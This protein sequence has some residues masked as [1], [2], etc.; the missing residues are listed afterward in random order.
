[1]GVS[2]T[3]GGVTGDGESHLDAV[4]P[5]GRYALGGVSADGRYVAFVS[6]ANNLVP[7]QTE[8]NPSNQVFLRDT[9]A[10][11]TTVVSH[12]FKS[13]VTT[14]NSESN[15]PVLSA[16]GRYVA[17]VSFAHNLV[18]EGSNRT[19]NGYNVF[20]YD[21]LTGLNTLVS[22]APGNF[23]Q[24]A[25]GDTPAISADG[26]WVAFSGKAAN[27]VAGITDTDFDTN[28]LLYNV[29]AGST[30]LITFDASNPHQTAQNSAAD[31]TPVLS[32]DGRYVAYVSTAAD[33]DGT[34]HDTNGAENVFRF[35]RVAGTNTLITRATTGMG[36]A[37]NGSS[38]APSISADGSR[39]AFVSYAT[40]LVPGQLEVAGENVFVS[41]PALGLVLVSHAQGAGR[42]TGDGSSYTPV[43]S[44][45]G[46]AIA[47]VSR[48][49]DLVANQGSFP[50][51]ENVFLFAVG[52]AGTNTLV[53]HAY[54]SATAS[55]GY[56]NAP[57]ISADGKAVA[58]WSTAGNLV[59]GQTGG[60]QNVFGYD[61]WLGAVHLISHVP[62]SDSTP[63]S[64]G[65]TEAPVISAD[66]KFIAFATR[67]SNL[68]SGDVIQMS[69]VFIADHPLFN[70]RFLVPV[71][72]LG[73]GQPTGARARPP[74]FARLI[75]V[76]VGKQER[77]LVE[78]LFAD[79]GALQSEF[80]APFQGPRYQ[81][82]QVRTVPG[83]GWLDEILVT[84]LKGKKTV[85]A[86]FPE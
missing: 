86:V 15:H 79:S 2:V 39:I 80:L 47:Y 17:Y 19:T 36:F 6:A 83:N 34:V 44:A 28:L 51:Q 43:I 38:F 56:S 41:D 37:G 35:D 4:S 24:E 48:A 55:G 71:P 53:S 61:A 32:A 74:L 1:V 59:A 85:T 81:G 21:R 10:G 58:F 26:N 70:P 23:T 75:R 29:Q 14:G 16:D 62:G 64:G 7:G 40:N 82:I 33:L 76:K 60:G 27:L 20:V 52:P 31:Y 13:P 63:G 50:G 66:G 22:H 67:D 42:N 8:P 69:N 84:A 3:P 11:T 78:V 57:S 49:T 46:S 12:A 30:R 72:G 18:D 5:E 45:D 54:G 25:G 9:V 68:V 73:T 65:A 77:W